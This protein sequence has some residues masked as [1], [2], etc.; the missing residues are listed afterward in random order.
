MGEYQ[1]P[2]SLARLASICCFCRRIR[3]H[4]SPR[5]VYVSLRTPILGSIR[6]PV[7]SLVGLGAPHFGQAKDKELSKSSNSSR[8]SLHCQ[9]N[10][11][12]IV[13]GKTLFRDLKE[14]VVVNQLG[15]NR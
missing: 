4:L 11:V 2:W 12:G 9:S 10:S 6:V 1:S 8:Q 5:V 3:A 14:L 13:L 7:I 15:K